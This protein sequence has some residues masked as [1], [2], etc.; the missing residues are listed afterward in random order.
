MLLNPSVR[1]PPWVTDIQQWIPPIKSLATPTAA[2]PSSPNRSNHHSP[3]KPGGA[4]RKTSLV[5][6][7]NNNSIISDS[8]IA[9]STIHTTTRVHTHH[10]P[11]GASLQKEIDTV[12]AT[13][14]CGVE[15]D[16]GVHEVEPDAAHDSGMPSSLCLLSLAEGTYSGPCEIELPHESD[17][18]VIRGATLDSTSNKTSSKGSSKGQ[19]QSTTGQ[20][21]TTFVATANSDVVLTVRRGTVWVE[22]MQ[23]CH[24]NAGSAL[25]ICGDAATVVA[26][27]SRLAAS[28]GAPVV[29]VGGAHGVLYGRQCWIHHTTTTTPLLGVGGV[30]FTSAPR[31]RGHARKCELA[32][33]R[34]QVIGGDGIIVGCTAAPV[35]TECVVTGCR[36]VG[37]DV[38]GAATPSLHQLRIEGNSGGGVRLSELSSTRLILNQVMCN[39][40]NGLSVND[41]AEVFAVENDFRDN[42]AREQI[43]LCGDGTAACTV[44]DNAISGCCV[45]IRYN[46]EPVYAS[47]TTSSPTAAPTPST[48]FV[49]D[50]NRFKGCKIGIVLHKS[51]LSLVSAESFACSTSLSY[52]VMLAM[53][54]DRAPS[55]NSFVYS[56]A[57]C[58]GFVVEGGVPTTETAE[59]DSKKRRG[60]RR[61]NSSNN[62]SPT[63][64]SSSASSPTQQQQQHSD[65]TV[66]VMTSATTVTML[67]DPH[68]LVEEEGAVDAADTSATTAVVVS[69]P[70][71]VPERYI[72]ALLTKNSFLE[73]P[74][75]ATGH[76]PCRVVITTPA[77]LERTVETTFRLRHHK[78]T[79]TGVRTGAAS[80]ML[81]TALSP[82]SAILQ[83]PK[84]LDPAATSSPRDDDDHMNEEQKHSPSAPPAPR[85]NSPTTTAAITANAVIVGHAV[86]THPSPPMPKS[87]GSSARSDTCADTFSISKGRSRKTMKKG[88]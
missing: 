78:R 86:R 68:T 27:N 19:P 56:H 15:L 8:S 2:C 43:L 80:T 35:I 41:A 54:S 85:T 26:M 57:D 88:R 53:V 84:A 9:T 45:G 28:H 25:R 31:S 60:S 7:S 12:V 5:A 62:P 77:E 3:R 66:S 10:V 39:D 82:R 30:V 67:S 70:P 11:A 47:S 38:S 83:A 74:P 63:R 4:H 59:T 36:G 34:L 58:L 44:R 20:Y 29:C 64:M 16:D 13:F 72:T 61:D 33:C 37:I 23:I 32:G 87:R 50:T 49:L 52:N 14:F 73:F 42:S 24:I 40:G 71:P 76:H 79:A 55:G 46:K 22:H 81:E 18:L 6:A 51:A 21:L 75:Q 65:D 48:N 17:V 1:L 69:P